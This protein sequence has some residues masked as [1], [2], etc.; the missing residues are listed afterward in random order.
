MFLGNIDVVG[1]TTNHKEIFHRVYND[2]FEY[3]I[4]I[5]LFKSS[6]MS[7]P[8]WGGWGRLSYKWVKIYLNHRV[9]RGH[10]VGSIAFF[11]LR[12][13]RENLVSFA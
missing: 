10:R 7:I 13:L 8:L 4:F 12:A 1:L 11:S 2:W 3:E 6:F 9:H 5:N